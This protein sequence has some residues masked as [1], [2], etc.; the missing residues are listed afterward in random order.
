[1]VDSS[2]RPLVPLDPSRCTF[3]ASDS[4]P[5]DRTPEAEDC[6]LQERIVPCSVA[7]LVC[8]GM[9]QAVPASRLASLSP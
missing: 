8:V 7:A 5:V 1:M 6:R 4:C 9:V 3:A 2:A